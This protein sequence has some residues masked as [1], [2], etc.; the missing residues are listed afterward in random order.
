MRIFEAQPTGNFFATDGEHETPFGGILF[1]AFTRRGDFIANDHDLVAVG[2]PSV[3]FK[4]SDIE[5][6]A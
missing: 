1:A 4:M 6:A 5:R 2:D 3:T